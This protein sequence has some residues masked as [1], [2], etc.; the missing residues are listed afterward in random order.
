M[1]TTRDFLEHTLD[2][3]GDCPSGCDVFEGASDPTP[4]RELQARHF[5]EIFAAQPVVNSLIGLPNNTVIEDSAGDVGVVM[6]SAAHYPET[7]PMGIDYVS[8]KYGPFTIRYA[9]KEQA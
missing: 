5:A 2:D 6:N 3:D 7:N 9:P 8:K 1:K 4:P